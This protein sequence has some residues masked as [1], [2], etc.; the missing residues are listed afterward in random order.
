VKS[1]LSN[2]YSDIFAKPDS[3]LG[4]HEAV[5]EPPDDELSKEADVDDD[6]QQDQQPESVAPVNVLESIL[7]FPN[8]AEKISEQ[9]FIQVSYIIE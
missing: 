8:S 7:R 4:R 3:H 6:R 2:F 9:S 1:F 5:E